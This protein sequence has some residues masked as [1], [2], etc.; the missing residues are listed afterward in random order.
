LRDPVVIDFRNLD[1]IGKK[2][3]SR[4]SILHE[5]NQ[6]PKPNVAVFWMA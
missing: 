2:T 1:A 5:Q 3:R 4:S 6:R